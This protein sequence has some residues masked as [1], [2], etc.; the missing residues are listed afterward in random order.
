MDVTHWNKIIEEV[1]EGSLLQITIAF[2]A[3]T[4]ITNEF[5]NTR[6]YMMIFKDGAL[7]VDKEYIP[8]RDSASGILEV[9]L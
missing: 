1:S 3:E 4:A 6:F 7:I 8:A 9:T 2:G 5:N